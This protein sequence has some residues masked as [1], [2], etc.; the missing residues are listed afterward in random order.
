M[1]DPISPAA[2]TAMP[3]AVGTGMA[4]EAG[5]RALES[6]G[7]LA[8]RIAGREVAAPATPGDWDGLARLLHEGALRDPGNAARLAEVQALVRDAL[9][10][11]RARAV[12]Q[13]PPSLRYFTDR[14]SQKR[15][16]GHQL[17]AEAGR[18]GEVDRRLQR[19]LPRQYRHA[20]LRQQLG[21]SRAPRAPRSPSP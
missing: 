8:R 17:T 21:T 19:L 3:G 2:V 1:V 11:A 7:G 9:P 10:E 13:L 16:M 15:S 12:P 18:D 4:N 14:D 5:K 20:G 6:V